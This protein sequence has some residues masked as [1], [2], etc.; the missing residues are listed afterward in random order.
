MSWWFLLACGGGEPAAP[1]PPPPA[2]VLPTADEVLSRHVQA[3]RQCELLTRD[4]F[5][6]QWNVTTNDGHAAPRK[7]QVVY[8]GAPGRTFTRIHQYR[9]PNK[10]FVAFGHTPDGTVW[11]AGET[12]IQTDLPAEIQATLKGQLDPTPICN[13]GA[14]WPVREMIGS[15]T[16]EDFPAWHLQLVWADGTDTDMWFHKESGLLMGSRLT[17]GDAVSTTTLTEYQDVPCAACSE[18]KPFRWPRKEKALRVEGP[19]TIETTQEVAAFVVDLPDFKEIGPVEIA[20]A[21]TVPA[22]EK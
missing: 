17:V 18:G 4:N 10:R 22:A 6:V 20:L 8:Q 2:P 9:E 12:G 3:T 7:E 13:Y 1:P 21:L 11:S 5:V 19:V 16:F 15:D 14:R